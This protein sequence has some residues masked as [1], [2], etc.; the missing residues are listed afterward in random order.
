MSASAVPLPRRVSE[1]NADAWEKLTTE[2]GACYYQRHPIGPMA[3][4]DSVDLSNFRVWGAKFGGPVAL[5]RDKTKPLKIGQSAVA[6]NKIFIFTAGG[7]LLSEITW[8][9]DEIAEMGWNDDENLVCMQVSGVA[10]VYDMHGTY[11]YEFHTGRSVREQG[12]SA[13]VIWGSGAVLLTMENRLFWVNGEGGF[14][15]ARTVELPDPLLDATPKCMSVVEPAL[16]GRDSPDVLLSAD[17]GTVMVVDTEQVDQFPTTQ[18]PFKKMECAANGQ[19]FACFTMEGQVVVFPNDFSDVILE[20]NTN[21]ATAPEQ[22]VWCGGDSVVLAYEKIVFMVGPSGSWINFRPDAAFVVVPEMDGVRILSNNTCEFLQRVPQDLVN[23]FQAG[24]VDPAAM[25]YDAYEELYERKSAKADEKMR[26]IEDDLGTAV[27]TCI[28]AATDPWE[29]DAQKKLLDAACYGKA[30]VENYDSGYFVDTCKDLRVLNMLRS[31]GIGIHLTYKQYEHLTPDVVVNRLIRRSHWKEA[32]T[33]CDY[34]KLEK[35]ERVAVQWACDKIKLEEDTPDQDLCDKIHAKLKDCPGGSFVDVAVV[36]DQENRKKLAVMLLD[37]EASAIDQVPL[38][39]QMDE[40][41]QALVKAVESGDTNLAHSVLMQLRDR[42]RDQ[43]AD[44]Y[45]SRNDFYAMLGRRPAAAN[46]FTSHLREK[47]AMEQAS[48]GGGTSLEDLKSFLYSVQNSADA[49][50][51]DLVAAYREPE[52]GD[53][54][55]NLEL[56]M[57]FLQQDKSSYFSAKMTEDQIKLV[58]IQRELELNCDGQVKYIDTSLADTIHSLIA[59]DQ[60]KKA[61]KLMKEFKLTDKRYAWIKMRALIQ[62]KQIPAL[63]KFSKEKKLPIPIES[64]VKC[65]IE[66][67]QPDDAAR[68]VTKLVDSRGN[69]L[70]EKQVTWYMQLEKYAEA[71]KVAVQC[72]DMQLVEQIK[73][74]V[75]PRLLESKVMQGVFAEAT[76]ELA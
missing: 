37:Y 62:S 9:G 76:R 61:T 21:S 28:A 46:L 12:V 23:V 26:A 6:N 57:D 45:L 44:D 19:L 66:D 10:I 55:R 70:A 35:S 17:D 13:C 38:L 3:W 52:L 39:L 2:D 64:F 14:E 11:R 27:N 20:F 24:S 53:R 58:S 74:Q 42:G 4:N 43:D 47:S 75:P 71:V 60:E 65:L 49:A 5:M 73:S 48:G 69:P 7:R 56:T 72:K 30:F 33:I 50:A 31:P 59:T 18:G 51:I 67:G 8:E 15:S 22:L 54:I 32:Y 16:T 29:A 68:F 40:P 41:E 36:A 63:E 34:L 25:L 1:L